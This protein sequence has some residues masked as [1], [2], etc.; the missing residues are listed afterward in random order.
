MLFGFLKLYFPLFSPFNLFFNYGF[1]VQWSKQIFLCYMF[2]RS[3]KIF[4]IFS[5]LHKNYKSTIGPHL[6]L[7]NIHNRMEKNVKILF[8]LV[9]STIL[10]QMLSCHF[11]YCGTCYRPTKA[12]SCLRHSCSKKLTEERESLT[13]K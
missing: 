10:Y 8:M 2:A 13:R 9:V 4:K 3:K 6:C 7:F 1:K 5:S 11:W 12:F